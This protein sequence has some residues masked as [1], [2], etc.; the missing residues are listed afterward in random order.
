MKALFLGAGASYEC[1]MPLV[2][3]FTNG[4]RANVLKRLDS[5]LFDFRKDPSFRARFEAILSDPNLHYEQ[6][7]GVLETLQ[8]ERGPSSDIARTTALQLVDCV[9]ILLLEDQLFTTNLLAEKAKDYSGIRGLLNKHPC[10]HV[11]SLNHDINFE[12]IC[13]FHNVECKDGFFDHTTERYS[14]IAKFKSL[15]KE[16]LNNGEFN[17]F[18]PEEVG[19]NLIK[20]HGSLDMFAV[21]DRN[22]YLKCAPPPNTSIGGHAQ[23]IRKIENKSLELSQRL[24]IR[25]VGE[26]DVTDKDGEIQFLRRSLLSGAHKFKGTFDQIAPVAFFE[27]FKK[28]MSAVTELDVIGYGFGDLHI[29]EFFRQWMEVP[30]VSM[31]I[32][33]PYRKSTPSILEGTTGKVCIFNF[34]LT[35]YF[36]KMEPSNNSLLLSF[37]KKSLELV[38]ENLRQRRLSLWKT[39]N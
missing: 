15:T 5:K 27:E 38:R 32:Y 18:G 36:Q 19:V 23:E 17:F 16:Q 26:L 31:S 25:T 3:E 1:G 28:R 6:M 24:K 30:D 37:R 33:D 14:N 39:N 9:Q 34:G 11:F 35:E 2:W 4:L 29:N 10:L 22:L 7:I 12:E 13:R 21:E 20:L 8:F